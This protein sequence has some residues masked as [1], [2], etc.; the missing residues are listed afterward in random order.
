MLFCLISLH[1]VNGINKVMM[2]MMKIIMNYRDRSSVVLHYAS[3]YASWQHPAM[4]RGASLAMF[5]TIFY[6]LLQQ[7]CFCYRNS[8]SLEGAS[9]SSLCF[10]E[11]L[12]RLSSS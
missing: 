2:M 7:H 6:F 4:E 12:A 5:V 8:A 11:F 3:K 1:Y 10:R 9:V